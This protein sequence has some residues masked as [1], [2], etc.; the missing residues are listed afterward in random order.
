MVEIPQV[1]AIRMQLHPGEA[2][3]YKKRH[4]EIWPELAS[5]LLKAGVIDFR[6]YLDPDSHALFAHLVTKA[7]N[8]LEGMRDKEIMWKWWSM[9]SDIMETNEDGSP[10]EWELVPMFHLSA[11]A[12]GART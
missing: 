3:A 2:A 11:D 9:M 7:G 4:D 10:R 1:T 8:A 5:E 6:I 12:V